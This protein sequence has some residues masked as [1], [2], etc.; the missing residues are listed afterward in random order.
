MRLS[1]NTI[2]ILN[3]HG[4]RELQ[5][6]AHSYTAQPKAVFLNAVRDER[7]RC[8]YESGELLWDYKHR[9]G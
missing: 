8:F 5:Q 7:V 3:A 9:R 1:Y 4:D 6:L 2:V